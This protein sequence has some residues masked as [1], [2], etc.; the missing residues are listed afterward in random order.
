MKSN[1]PRTPVLFTL[2]KSALGLTAK[3]SPALA[4]LM[5]HKFW[6]R[7]FRSKEPGRETRFLEKAQWSTVLVNG[8]N[9]QVYT[10]GEGP[11]I[12]MCH[13]W[14]GR[15]AQFSHIASALI[16][17]GYQVVLLDNPGHGRSAG[18][19]SSVK[20]FSQTL[21]SLSKHYHPIAIITHSLGGLALLNAISHGLS[22]KQAVCI[23]PPKD[24]STLTASFSQTM[25]L[26]A[27]VEGHHRQ[28]IE[29][30]FGRD[31]WNAFSMPV[32]VKDCPIPGMIIHDQTD[33]F[34]QHDDSREIASLWP[35]CEFISTEKLGHMRILRDKSVIE[36]IRH[37][38]SH[39]DG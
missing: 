29:Q 30:Q 12:M 15:G 16:K 23:A 35:G 26:P 34:T 2:I 32:L 22:I 24:V 5:A 4:G 6:I 36:R 25:A 37:F 8:N 27:S 7:T 3:L 14:N 38:L 33:R 20:A 19:T 39:G 13:G 10:V 1:K 17:D 28:R 31:V 9:V 18:S 21:S 11:T